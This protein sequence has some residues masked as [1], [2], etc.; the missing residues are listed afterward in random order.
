MPYH[1]LKWCLLK[2]WCQRSADLPILIWIAW[3]SF[4]VLRNDIEGRK[5]GRCTRLHKV[6]QQDRRFQA[7]AQIHSFLCTR[8]KR[9]T[10]LERVQCRQD[11]DECTPSLHDSRQL[12]RVYL[13]LGFWPLPSRRK[14][15]DPQWSL[16]RHSSWLK[17]FIDIE[18]RWIFDVHCRLA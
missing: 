16:L 12:L 8:R 15:R 1:R 17:C 4:R 9:F 2:L 18:Q 14:L 11:I 5:F 3:G 13:V 6:L 10:R 7:H